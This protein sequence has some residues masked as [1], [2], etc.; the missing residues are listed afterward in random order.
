MSKSRQKISVKARFFQVGAPLL[1]ALI[2][3]F[4]FKLKVLTP[5]EVSNSFMEPSFSQGKTVY[6]NK[7][8]SVKSLLVGDVVLAK[9]PLDEN[10][11][12]LARILGKPGD[13]VYISAREAYRNGNPVS[14]EIF[15]K[16]KSQ[17]LPILPTGKTESDE[18]PK[19][20]VPEK[21]FF[22]LCDNREIG[23]DSR[24]L[25]PIPESLI[26]GKVW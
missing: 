10:S 18:K 9:S 14:D 8:T 26:I 6:I 7:L 16:P 3:A 21:T 15:P 4:I 20:I 23:I 13:E 24:E 12:I 17:N 2:L 11:Y 25:G 5:L 22:L 19:L 1:I